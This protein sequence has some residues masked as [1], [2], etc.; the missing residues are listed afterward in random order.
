MAALVDRHGIEVST[1]IQAAVQ[2]A[3]RFV[4]EVLAY[5]N[6]WQCILTAPDTDPSWG[7][8]HVLCADYHMSMREAPVDA[9][10]CLEAAQ[11]LSG[12]ATA[13]EALY[14]EAYEAL[15]VAGDLRAAA[16]HFAAV[17]EKHPGDLLA[18]KRCQLLWF[19]L[20]EPE[21]M[22][23]VCQ[24][25]VAEA[26]DGRAFF[27]GM[28]AF[29]LE[30]AG[31]LPEAEA[32]ARRGL[33]SAQEAEVSDP[34]AHHALAHALYFQGQ[35][36]EGIQLLQG[37]ADEWGQCCSFMLTHNW[38]HIAL[39]LLDR[40]APGDWDRLEELF[41]G[42][43]WG[44]DKANIQD[45]LGALGL[46]AKWELR[47][48]GANAL[49]K[50]KHEQRWIDVLHHVARRGSGGTGAD[51]LFD[52]LALYGF[53]RMG[54]QDNADALFQHIT[55]HAESHPV[56]ER[57]ADLTEVWIPFARGVRRFAADDRAA[58]VSDMRGAW[59]RLAIVGG[60][61][62]QRD[63]LV[64]MFLH[65]L[66]A[67]GCW[68]E[69]CRLLEQRQRDRLNSI[70]ETA[71]LLALVYRMR[72]DAEAEGNARKELLDLGERYAME[73]RQAKNLGTGSSFEVR[74]NRGVEH[75]AAVVKAAVVE[76][77]N[78]RLLAASLAATAIAAAAAAVVLRSNIL[79]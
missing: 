1:T 68:D 42:R 45:Q 49:N 54:L 52:L 53:S 48:V 6:Q 64:E 18:L 28:V 56:Q 79:P 10:T 57:R 74:E 24:G 32:T 71:R 35:L 41:D 62:E 29:A 37:L 39:F 3:D 65:A 76:A 23:R 5:G 43:I 2:A 40:A 15:V 58:A 21:E 14:L 34:W 60:S 12:T 55:A 44:V 9:R 69:A 78:P 75:I 20:G 8:G 73:A 59:R 36:S 19:F 27:D 13:R 7:L 22:L 11:K 47:D 61:S 30:Q 67:A 16:I 70:P 25:P 38:W 63:V 72:G 31:Q 77:A 51:P 26:N 17:L 50:A 66:L 4:E 46:L 33:V